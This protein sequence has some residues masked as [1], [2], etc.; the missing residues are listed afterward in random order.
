MGSI[1]AEAEGA[2]A[3]GEPGE[4]PVA[5]VLIVLIVKATRLRV[6]V[7]LDVPPSEGPFAHRL[8]RE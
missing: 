6:R 2:L 7:T 3:L 1:V 8:P 4:N 5:I